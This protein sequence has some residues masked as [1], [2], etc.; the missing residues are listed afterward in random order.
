MT[1]IHEL[2]KLY[3]AAG[4]LNLQLITPRRFSRN[5]NQA[6][7]AHMRH[8]PH[9]RRGHQLRQE[10]PDLLKPRRDIEGRFGTQGNEVG[11]LG[12]LPNH[13]RRLHRVQRWVAGKL[14]INAAHQHARIDRMFA[15]IE[16]A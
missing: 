12:P 13:V 10:N 16:A 5:D 15:A 4:K 3:E 9:R 8:S 7:L 1:A 11:G 6:S 14:L 2:N